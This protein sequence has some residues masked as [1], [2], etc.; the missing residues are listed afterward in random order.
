MAAEPARALRHAVTALARGTASRGR[1]RVSGVPQVCGRRAPRNRGARAQRL[2]A[3]LAAVALIGSLGGCYAPQM[4]L[5]KSGLDS[6]RTT[7]DTL[8]V[9]DSIAYAMLE[10]TRR[11]IANQKD[12]LL[13]TRASSGSTTQ[14]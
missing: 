13:S 2:L 12:I 10:E 11:E 3:G 6:L 7:V 4:V 14:E 8:M 1:T 5:I 9:R